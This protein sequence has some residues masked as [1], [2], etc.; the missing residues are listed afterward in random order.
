MRTLAA[1]DEQVLFWVRHTR[2]G[3][4]LCVVLPG[5]VALHTWLAPDRPHPMAVYALAAAVA[6]SS[7]ILLLVP[8]AR[9]VRHPRGRLF[10]DVWEALGVGIVCALALLDDGARSPYLLFFY[11][12]LA[13]AALAYA[14]SAM[15]LAGAGIIVGFL[16][17]GLLA[18]TPRRASSWSAR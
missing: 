17:V 11:V 5:I 13:H 3:V 2:L 15:V 16:S 6:L 4:A 9:L 1:D 18:G 8:V 12:L 7:P 14:P 10:F